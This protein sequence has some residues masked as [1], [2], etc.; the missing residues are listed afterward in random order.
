METGKKATKATSPSF[1][2]NT[3]IFHTSTGTRERER[4]ERKNSLWCALC[5]F[6]EKEDLVALLLFVCCVSPEIR[7]RVNLHHLQTHSGRHREKEKY[8]VNPMKKSSPDICHCGVSHSFIHGL[9]SINDSVCFL[10]F[11]PPFS[12]L[13]HHYHH[14][15]S[16]L[17][18]IGRRLSVFCCLTNHIHLFFFSF[19]F[20]FLFYFILF[21]FFAFLLLNYHHLFFL[22]LRSPSSPSPPFHCAPF[23]SYCCGV[24]DRIDEHLAQ[25]GYARKRILQDSSS[26]V[27]LFF[28]SFLFIFNLHGHN[29]SPSLFSSTL[30]PTSLKSHSAFGNTKNKQPKF[31]A[32]SE[33][34]NPLNLLVLKL[35][36]YACVFLDVLV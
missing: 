29:H 6:A 23:S 15:P 36:I 33:S 9:H 10:P 17:L 14:T 8:L 11:F 28:H 16:P 31:Q 32:A 26:L 35:I 25:Q 1:L 21:Y 3:D 5:A 7:S 12:L 2:H 22:S 19:F 24:M 13:F 30:N 27:S 34:L 20:Y 18:L 4:E